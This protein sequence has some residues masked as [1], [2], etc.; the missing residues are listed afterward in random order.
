MPFENPFFKK[1]EALAPERIL[2][3]DVRYAFQYKEAKLGVSEMRDLVENGFEPEALY[4][5]LKSA[6]DDPELQQR[7]L[8]D[9][10]DMVLKEEEGGGD[11]DD[12]RVFLREALSELKD[13]VA[14]EAQKVALISRIGF[15]LWHKLYE[16]A[17]AKLAKEDGE[18]YLLAHSTFVGLPAFIEQFSSEG[19]PL[20]ILVPEFFS[21][22][23]SDICGYIIENGTVSLLPKDFAR[24]DAAVL[25]DDVRNTGETLEKVKAFWEQDGVSSEPAFSVLYES[26]T[27]TENK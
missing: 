18:V 16:D 6:T 23:E 1:K 17:A 3:S 24:P 27:P 15:E 7:M 20:Q 13:D 21:D 14:V 8:Q 25:V 2:P 10:V 12:M 26:G 19:K 5:V 4:L 9:L 22:E 11:Q